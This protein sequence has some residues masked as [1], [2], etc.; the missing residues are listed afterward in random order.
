MRFR[1]KEKPCMMLLTR[2]LHLHVQ[3]KN[4]NKLVS[5]TQ[6]RSRLRDTE[7]TWWL[8]VRRGKQ[9]GQ[10][11]DEGK[12]RVIVRLYEILCVNRLKIVKHYRI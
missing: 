5:N 7:K 4:Y 3:Y 10:D 11:R 9:G 1:V 6:K 8:P 12:R 2:Y